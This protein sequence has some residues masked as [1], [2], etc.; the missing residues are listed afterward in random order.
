VIRE[1]GVTLLEAN[2]LPVGMFHA[3]RFAPDRLR[4]APGDTLVLCSDGVTEAV[5][6]EEREYG[7]QRLSAVVRERNGLPVDDL[8]EACVRDLA[9]HCRAAPLDDVTILVV[10]RAPVGAG[11]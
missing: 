2:G 5:D 6:A 4:L 7:L 1:D 8:V 10:R 3:E 9:D 11:H